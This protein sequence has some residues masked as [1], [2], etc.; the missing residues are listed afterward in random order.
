[1]QRSEII[2]RVLQAPPE[3][4][5]AIDAAA[6]GVTPAR[7]PQP[8][9]IRQVAEILGVCIGTVRRMQTRG[10]ITPRRFSKRLLR[11][12]RSEVEA[13]LNNPQNH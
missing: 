6:R 8:I 4:Y 12:E 13:L 9:T 3:A 7:K 1:M 5:P 11:Y 10:L 2:D